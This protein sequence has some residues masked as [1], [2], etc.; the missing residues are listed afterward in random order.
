LAGLKRGLFTGKGFA[1]SGDVVRGSIGIDD[2]LF[3]EFPVDDYLIEPE[4]ALLALPEKKADIHKYSAGKVLTIAGSDA[5]P[6][7][8]LMTAK[9]AMTA[10]AGASILSIPLSLKGIAHSAY[11]E[12]VVR[13]YD[14]ENCTGRLHPG[15]L[16]EL[17]SNLAWADVIALGPG[18]GRDEETL[19][20]VRILM[21]KR[22]KAAFVIDA[23]GLYPFNNGEYKKYNFKNT[24]LTPHTGEF[25]AML[26]IPNDE[27]QDDMLAYGKEFAGTTGAFLLLKSARS[28]LFTPGGEALINSAGNPGMAKF[29]T[30][31]VLTGMLAGFIAQTKDI[32]QGAIAA[33]YLHSLSADLLAAEKSEYSYSAVDIM[34]N[35][36]AA[37]N[38]LRSSVV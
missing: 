14:D 21:K 35:L 33:L 11:P 8:A 25:A 23:D 32:E 22:G 15:A 29:G 18:L 37:I 4:D 31:D 16:K 30:G 36:P 10:G 13:A 17:S 19:K 2:A 27:L 7:A 6:G 9:S 20:A 38:F 1:A 5:F 28:I 26:G 24:L 3:D 12:L 34:E